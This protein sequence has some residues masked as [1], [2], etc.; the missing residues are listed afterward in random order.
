MSNALRSK[1][2]RLRARH[3]GRNSVHKA[4]IGEP[5]AERDSAT[6]KTRARKI[7]GGFRGKHT[8]RTGLRFTLKRF[9][10]AGSIIVPSSGTS[11][12]PLFA[13][14]D[15][16]A[17]S[18]RECFPRRRK[19]KKKKKTGFEKYFA[20]TKGKQPEGG[21]GRPGPAWPEGRRHS[22]VDRTR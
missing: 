14:K 2:I 17:S 10:S 20:W 16:N 18:R 21:F 11:R 4:T 8:G 5:S 7:A 19:K 22:P 15:K 9:T 13:V 6:K 3:V 1:E 12:L